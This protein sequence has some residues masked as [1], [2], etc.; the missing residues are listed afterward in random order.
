MHSPEAHRGVLNSDQHKDREAQRAS[1]ADAHFAVTALRRHATLLILAALF[2][3]AFLPR[4]LV[5][6]WGLPYVEHPDEPAVL[7]PVVK[8]EQTAYPGC[9]C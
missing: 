9:C 1:V 6:G 3:L 8:L 7:E 4:F 2:G 5:V